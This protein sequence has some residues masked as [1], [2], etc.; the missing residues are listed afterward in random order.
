MAI[1]PYVANGIC[2][3]IFVWNLSLEFFRL[4][5]STW[6]LPFGMFRLGAFVFYIFR[7][8]AWDISSRGVRLGLFAWGP[9]LEKLL[10]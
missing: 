8:G 3:G 1:K 9:S 6:K 2:L 5:C 10:F 4:G 7:L